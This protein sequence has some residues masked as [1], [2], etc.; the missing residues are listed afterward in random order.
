MFYF[1]KLLALSIKLL[2]EFS[3]RKTVVHG[4]SVIPH[5]FGI[6]LFEHSVYYTD[7]TKMAVMKSN[8]YSDNS[9]QELYRTSQR[10]H[11]LTVVH[12][13]RQP[14]GKKLCYVY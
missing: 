13:Y 8:K 10:P 2:F 3:N 7:W 12:A 6:T 9:P 14:F 1:F 5:P 11:G 4:G